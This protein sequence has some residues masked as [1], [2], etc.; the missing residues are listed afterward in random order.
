MLGEIVSPMPPGKEEREPAAAGQQ[1]LVFAAWNTN[2]AI[3]RESSSGGIFTLLAEQTIAKGGVVFGAAFDEQLNLRHIAVETAECLAALRSSKYLQSKTGS[4]FAQTKQLLAAGRDVL[5]TGTPCQIAGLKSFLGPGF[6]TLLTCDVVCHGVSS[7]RMFRKYIAALEKQHG[8]KATALCFR[9]KSSGWKNY[10]VRI[11]FENGSTY[12]A[13]ATEDPFMLAYL[14]NLCLRSGCYHC[15]FAAI[16]RQGDITLGDYWG[17]DLAHPELDDNRGTSLV[18][19][20]TEKGKESL[21]ALAGAIELH[22]SS[23]TQAAR[24]NPSLTR[25]VGPSL[26]REEFMND[27]DALP[28][29]ELRIKYLMPARPPSLLRRVYWRVK[30][31]LP[32][33]IKDYFER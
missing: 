23:L 25:P 32:P 31:L 14:R 22:P 21:A 12:R 9:D 16:P 2:A 8:A 3:R 20:N 29:A 18:L 6:A 13:P 4:T 15:P 7:E 30:R 24:C 26:Q 28:F 27:L 10:S 17:L 11:N 19:A 33:G 1:P 5:Y